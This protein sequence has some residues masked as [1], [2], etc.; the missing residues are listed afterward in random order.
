MRYIN[1]HFTYLLTYFKVKN[2]DDDTYLLTYLLTMKC[3]PHLMAHALSSVR[4]DFYFWSIAA[5]CP[6]RY[7]H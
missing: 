5:I 2:D 6:S 1:L 4:R 3:T 7:N